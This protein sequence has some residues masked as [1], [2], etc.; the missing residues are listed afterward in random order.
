MSQALPTLVIGHRNPDMDTIGAAV[1]YAWLLDTLGPDHYV[2]GRTG[3]IN[4]Q[5]AFAVTY[6]DVPVPELVTDVAPHVRDAIRPAPVLHAG[7]PLRDAVQAMP[8]DDSAAVVLD[9]SH[10]P[11]GS[12]SRAELFAAIAPT[13]TDPVALAK[14][15]DRPVE[16]VVNMTPV[17]LAADASVR[18]VLNGALRANTSVFVVIDAKGKYVGLCHKADLLSPPHRKVVLVDHNEPAQAVGGLDEAELVEVLDHHRLGNPGT[19]FPIRF[20]V[21]PVGSC[22]T[23]VAEQAFLDSLTFPKPVAGLLLSGILSD[24]LVFKSPTSTFRDRRTAEGLAQMAGLNGPDALAQYGTALLAAGAGLSAHT[25][26]DEIIKADFKQYDENGYSAGVS[27]VEVAGFS[28]LSSR[29][30]ELR[31]ALEKARESGKLSLAILVVTDII[32]SNS[33]LI[34]V[35]QANLIGALPYSR[36]PDGTLYAPGLVSRKKQLL[37]VILETL[38]KA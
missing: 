16:S 13:L 28:E 17:T 18:E 23:L 3:E 21:D 31:K 6:F 32:D 34:A 27:Q 37:P 15:L 11:I 14:T 26:E 1:G 24:T 22:S 9:P 35:G 25:D 29:L 30:T 8:S 4:A 20:R 12:L 2:P 19:V 38:Q 5:T 7:Q 36:L 10:K 33:R